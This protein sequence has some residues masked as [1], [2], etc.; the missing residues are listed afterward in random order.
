MENNTI[1]AMRCKSEMTRATRHGQPPFAF[2]PCLMPDPLSGIAVHQT[3][4]MGDCLFLLFSYS[5]PWSMHRGMS[6]RDCKAGM[7]GIWKRVPGFALHQTSMRR[8]R[9]SAHGARHQLLLL[10]FSLNLS[11]RRHNIATIKTCNNSSTPVSS[12]SLPY[13]RS[14]PRQGANL[15]YIGT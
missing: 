11:D 6:L 14:R 7:Y 13:A 10:L 9:L 3:G 1:D 15:A 8:H 12:I 5:R 4:D 2:Q